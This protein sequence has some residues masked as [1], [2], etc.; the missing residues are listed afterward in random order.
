MKYQNLFLKLAVVGLVLG[1]QAQSHASL[2]SV[3][4]LVTPPLISAET[5]AP[6]EVAVPLRFAKGKFHVDRTVLSFD[7]KTGQTQMERTPVCTETPDVAVFDLRGPPKDWSVRISPLK[8]SDEVQGV[9]V[10]VQTW[11]FMVLHEG[12]TLGFDQPLKS[13]VNGTSINKKVGPQIPEVPNQYSFSTDL[14]QTFY[15]THSSANQYVTCKTPEGL[16]KFEPGATTPKGDCEIVNPIAYQ[17]QWDAEDSQ[18]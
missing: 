10:E 8:C 16:K 18:K 17:V 6:P 12:Q 7:E 2:Q 11:A 4:K 9:K 15:G 1:L 3:L 14:A 5:S 13:F